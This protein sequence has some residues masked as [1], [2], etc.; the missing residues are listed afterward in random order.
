MVVAAR[1]GLNEDQIADCLHAMQGDEVKD[2]LKRTTNEAL[3]EGAFGLP[4]IITR[5]RRGD[6]EYFGCD[7]FEIMANRLDLEWLG[8]VPPEVEE[9][10]MAPPPDADHVAI[11]QNLEDIEAIKFN[12]GIDLEGIFKG[13]PL[14]GDP[15]EEDDLKTK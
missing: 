10:P 6:E 8:P 4:F 1:G 2:E 9:L 13:V 15:N 7:R 12:A 3:E 11:Q 14:K 5:H